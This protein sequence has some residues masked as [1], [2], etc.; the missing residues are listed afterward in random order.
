MHV[1][2]CVYVCMYIY[3]YI[4]IDKHNYMCIYTHMHSS[5]SPYSAKAEVRAAHE[6]VRGGG[7]QG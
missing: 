6:L 7:G 3:I 1:C 2:I 5:R 4:Y